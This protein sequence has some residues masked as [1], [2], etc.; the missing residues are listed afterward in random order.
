MIICLAQE[1]PIS[2]YHSETPSE[3][4]LS[5]GGQLNY[6]LYRDADFCFMY[7]FSCQRDNRSVCN[8]NKE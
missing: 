5:D 6:T 4:L 7:L 1:E 8:N 2:T 3:I